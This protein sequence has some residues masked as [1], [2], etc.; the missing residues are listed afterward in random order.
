MIF[1][2]LARQKPK[3]NNIIDTNDVSD[4]EA[5]SSSKRKG[6]HALQAFDVLSYQNGHFAS[7]FQFLLL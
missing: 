1:L 2:P 6:K 5:E 3:G 4:G 7:T